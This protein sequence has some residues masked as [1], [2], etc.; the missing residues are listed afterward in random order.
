MKV[1]ICLGLSAGVALLAATGCAQT[2]QSI[3]RGQSP[4]VHAGG[5]FDGPVIGSAPGY[6]EHS[7]ASSKHHDFKI[8]DNHHSAMYGFDDGAYDCREQC[9]AN[10]HKRVYD[11]GGSSMGCPACNGGMNCPAGG[12]PHCGCGCDHGCPRHYHTYQYKWPQN[13]VYPPPVVPAGMVQY[14]YYTLRGPSDFFM[15]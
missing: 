11:V 1:G 6:G 2:Q 14:P 4:V 7:H 3:V 15:K 8:L 10:H 5:E 12:C 13:L 9:Y